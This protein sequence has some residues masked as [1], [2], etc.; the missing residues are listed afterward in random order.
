MVA[1]SCLV[2]FFLCGIPS[3]YI[4]G[5]AMGQV[6]IRTLGSGNVGSTN[7]ARSL[8]AKAGLLTL[9]CDILKAVV[10]LLVAHVLIGFVGTGEGFEQTCPG[11]RYDWCMSLVYLFAL[12]G[13]IFSPFLKFHG[14]KGI[15]VGFGGAVVL[16]PLAGVSLW[17]PFLLLA[18][19][20]RYVSAGSI[21]AALSMPFLANLFYNPS[22]AFTA[23][24]IACSALVV[25]SHR[26]NIVKLIHGEERRFSLAKKE[27]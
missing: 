1:A 24:L 7:V 11:G 10:A 8:G 13:H 2:A 18:V 22:V 3:A 15:A 9:V 19:P 14:G 17:V 12:L 27:K 4:V 20:T 6:D 26:T 16:I 25:W 5:R 21:A 23:I